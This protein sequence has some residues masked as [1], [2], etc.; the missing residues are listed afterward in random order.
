MRPETLAALR[1]CAVRDPLPQR[2][3]LHEPR[4]THLS[5]DRGP[6]LDSGA[7]GTR[8]HGRPRQAQRPPDATPHDTTTVRTQRSAVPAE[9]PTLLTAPHRPQPHRGCGRRTTLPTHAPSIACV[10]SSSLRPLPSRRRMRSYS[11]HIKMTS[12]ADIVSFR[13]PQSTDKT[14]HGTA[15]RPC[16][17]QSI[18][19]AP[20][21]RIPPCLASTAEP[22][23]A[24]QLV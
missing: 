7:L 20:P 4:H 17:M 1:E 14:G 6:R 12:H 11:A 22:R 9:R 15:S 21:H 2:V 18:P 3:H 5:R 13:R 23:T 24:A 10:S 8:A 19:H 16:R